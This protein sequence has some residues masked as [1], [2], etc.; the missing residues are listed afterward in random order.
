LACRGVHS[1]DGCNPFFERL[2]RH[3]F[4]RETG[5]GGDLKGLVGVQ[6]L[7]FVVCFILMAK[8][9]FLPPIILTGLESIFLAMTCLTLA[10]Q[11]LL[12]VHRDDDYLF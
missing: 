2:D 4:A 3:L 12:R 7:I 10:V 5:A 1:A 6:I 9:T 11:R 8:F